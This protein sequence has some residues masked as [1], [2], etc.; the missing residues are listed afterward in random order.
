[1]PEEHEAD[2]GDDDALLD[3]LFAQRGD[4]SLDE[5]GAIIGGDDFDTFRQGAFD[6]L[7]F[8]FDSIDDTQRI[9]PVAHD[10]D[11]ADDLAFAVEFGDAA[12]EVGAEVNG[13]DIFY[14]NWRAILGFQGDILDVLNTFDVAA[15]AHVV[16]GG[17]DLED[18]S[19][20]VAIGHADFVDD[21]IQGDAVGQQFVWIDVHLVLLYETAHGRDL[22]NPFDGF[23]SIAQVPVLQRAQFGKVMFAG[24]IHESVLENPADAG[25]IRPDDGI[26]TV[27]QHA[28]NGS[29]VFDD[30]RPRPVNVGAV[31][32]YDV[33][34]GLA[35]HGFAA[36]EL[37]FGR[38]DE[39]R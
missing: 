2:Q 27:G 1:M 5:L 12:A 20:H 18:L 19:A 39:A 25:S 15:P 38:G 35:K 14:K 6:F 24:F 10:N 21:F 13:A 29:E 3:E 26:H 9:L 23:K 28:A 22:G 7:Q 36:N 17:G 16:F 30:T 32:E 11:A 4:G 33:D 37:H 31:L 34:E 8:P